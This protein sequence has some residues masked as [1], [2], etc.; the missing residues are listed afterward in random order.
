MRGS[1]SWPAVPGMRGPNATWVPRS[2]KARASS[3]AANRAIGASGSEEGEAER[4]RARRGRA[5]GRGS[6][7]RIEPRA[8]A[9][10]RA[11]FKQALEAHVGGAPRAGASG[12]VS[13][14]PSRFRPC[15]SRALREAQPDRAVD[16]VRERVGAARVEV[17]AVGVASCDDAA[18]R[19]RSSPLACCTCRRA[20]SV[21]L[22]LRPV[23]AEDRDLLPRQVGAADA[24]RG[25][26]SCPLAAR[27][28]GRE[29]L[30][31]RARAVDRDLHLRLCRLRRARRARAAAR[32]SSSA[33]STSG[34]RE[35]TPSIVSHEVEPRLRAPSRAEHPA[36][37]QHRSCTGPSRSCEVG[38]RDVLAVRH[39]AVVRRG[40]GSCSCAHAR[41]RAP[42]QARPPSR[43]RPSTCAVRCRWPAARGRSTSASSPFH[44][45]FGSRTRPRRYGTEGTPKKR[46]NAG[47]AAERDAHADVAEPR[48]R[49]PDGHRESGAL[50]GATAPA[51]GRAGRV[52]R[53]VAR[54]GRVAGAPARPAAAERRR[55]RGAL[56]P[57][58]AGRTAAPSVTPAFVAFGNGPSWRLGDRSGVRASTYARREVERRAEE[59]RG[60]GTLK[61]PSM[62][63]GKFVM[64]PEVDAQ[65]AR[66]RD[67]RDVG[68]ARRRDPVAAERQRPPRRAQLV[69]A[70][71]CDRCRSAASTR[72][73]G[74]R[75]RA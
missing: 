31:R 32:S 48:E 33:S 51:A 2:A 50:G 69:D 56:L 34:C 28:A 53:R 64:L 18:P 22:R 44:C 39:L 11:L 47:R 61:R 75:G 3:K 24:S 66:R 23:A 73:P 12:V 1:A 9:R 40:S 4:R 30:A 62:R 6:C 65:D 26:W 52:A 43:R 5:T 74:R 57:S 8:A 46:E 15:R 20:C 17:D 41:G 70:T 72:R 49:A 25:R 42:D 45:V 29:V 10:P 63:C 37:A 71:A 7:R 58:R 60:R 13:G 68:V 67:A 59:R 27:A 21:R 16:V 38:E 55:R 36:Q 14:S 54:D 35:S 19:P